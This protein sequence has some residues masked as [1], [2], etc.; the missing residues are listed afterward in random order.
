MLHD[1]SDVL[2]SFLMHAGFMGGSFCNLVS[3]SCTNNCIQV[4]SE[5]KMLASE[6]SYSSECKNPLCVSLFIYVWLLGIVGF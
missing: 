3:L 1:D 5:N 4:K 6:A 2:R